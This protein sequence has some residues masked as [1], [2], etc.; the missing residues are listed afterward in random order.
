MTLNRVGCIVH[1]D[2]RRVQRRVRR[3]RWLGGW[4]FGLALLVGP[5][6]AAVADKLPEGI[7]ARIGGQEITLDEYHGFLAQRLRQKYFH[8]RLIHEEM[9]RAQREITQELIDHYLAA[10]EAA[11]RGLV[12]QHAESGASTPQILAEHMAAL[13]EQLRTQVVVSDADVK[14]FY[15]QYP[16]KFT[17]PDQLRL[18]VILLGVPPYAP[19]EEWQTAHDQ[20]VGLRKRIVDQ[21]DAFDVVAREYSKHE[22]AAKGG[23][24]G[25]VHKGRLAP[26][27]EGVVEQLAL[28]TVSEPVPLLQGVALF[29]VEE[30]KPSHLN[31]FENVADRA[32]VLLVNERSQAAWQALIDKLRQ[33]TPIA[34]AE[35]A[36]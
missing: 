4:A 31:P 14:A 35:G 36:L 6:M 10:Q 29:R 1:N 13:R 24:L 2:C 27:V 26:E 9:A 5:A 28:G 20:A 32:R 21:G 17:A 8:G 15:A 19:K 16:D 18:S 11:R 33:T 23:D 7:F 12:A 34:V 22:S 3:F 30:R 25:F